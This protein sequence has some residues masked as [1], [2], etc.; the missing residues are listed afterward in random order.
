MRQYKEQLIKEKVP[1]KLICNKCGKTITAE[2]GVL[3][4][5]MYHGE[6]RWGYFSEKDGELHRFDLCEECYD[7]LLR[8]FLIQPEIEV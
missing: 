5:E 4:G 8:S 1:K 7:E 3:K 6:Y 2:N